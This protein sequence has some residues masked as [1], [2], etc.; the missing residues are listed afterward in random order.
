[1]R[2]RALL[3]TGLILSLA[4]GA[5]LPA[6]AVPDCGGEHD[7]CD[8]GRANYCLCDGTC[9]NC[10][11]HAWH[12]AC[13]EWGRA[14][15][16][17]T[18]AGTWDEHARSNGYPTG[19]EARDRSVF[20]C[21]PSSSC[22][23]WG[24]VGWVVRAYPDGSFDS[25]E[26]FWGGPCGTHDRHHGA[27]FA[28]GGFIYDPGG[29]SGPTDHDDADFVSESVPDG[30]HF[31]PG[32]EFDKRWTLRNTGNTT[33]TRDGDYL[34]THDGDERFGAEE[35]TRLPGD[36][37]VGPGETWDF[38]VRMR[39]PREPGTYRGYW[40][41]DRYGTHRF[42]DRIWVE[43]VVDAVE[44][45]ADGDGHPADRDC[46]DGDG[47]IHPGAEERCNGR[48][49]DCDGEVDEGVRN[50]C[51]ECGPEPE[52]VCDGADNDCDGEIDEGVRNRC[53]ECGPEPE[54]V[55]D[56]ED[57]DC[58]GEIDE[59]CGDPPTDAGPD[60][61][62]PS[63]GGTDGGGDVPWDGGGWDG[64]WDP[65]DAGPLP[66]SGGGGS[67]LDYVP[68][69]EGGCLCRQSA[70]GNRPSLPLIGLVLLGVFWLRRRG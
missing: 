47:S 61:G 13:C 12:M 62:D 23:G 28:T 1:M 11:W 35:Q 65:G 45:D 66:D 22:S 16:W 26:Q 37:R 54:E 36:A 21:N 7:S 67:S 57:N 5:P 2:F 14:L 24:H 48:D 31:R 43:I 56:G 46:D 58:D 52:E 38:V 27:G 51:G 53:G 18:D 63:D 20:V 30:T 9:G 34:L 60:S 8:C 68:V 40:R 42:G 49:D 70:S 41:M 59:G 10:V 15:E 55:C 69:M 39:A 25:T 29:S 33:W 17:C 32:E 19:G 50:R 44:V 64:G 4:L 3:T 6:G